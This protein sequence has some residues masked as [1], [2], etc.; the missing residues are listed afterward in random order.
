MTPRWA[1]A[2]PA[3][4]AGREVER[5][6]PPSFSVVIAAYQAEA[7]VGEAIASA[8]AQTAPPLEVVVVDDGSTDGTAGVVAS[9]GDRV[10]FLRRPNGGEGAAKNMGARA[11]RGEF[12]VILD[13]DDTFLPERL[14]ALGTLAAARPDLDVLTTDAWLV[15]DG[16][17]VRRVYDGGHA[18][19][20]VDQR[21]ELMRRNFVFGHAAVRRRRFL[22]V[23][24]FDENLRTTTDWDLWIRLALS[25]SGFGLVA[26]PLATY[27]MRPDSIS[28]DWLTVVAAR[29][30][31]LRKT[32]AAPELSDADRRLVREAAAA[33]ERALRL[34]QARAAMLHAR[35]GARGLAWAVVTDPGQGPRSRLKALLATASPALA[36][37][38][39]V[40]PGAR[41]SA[42]RATRLGDAAVV[43]RREG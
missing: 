37:R 10:R 38:L 16:V 40:R 17:R 15:V 9:F 21:T 14:E 32:G 43:P 34:G 20:V 13:A 27:R 3:P 41:A 42:S 4:A 6:D 36:R 1:L 26:E 23:G 22:A 24:G 7:F 8:L 11:A 35:P 39:L 29:I 5:R 33:Q 25:G 12:V 2:T 31:V 18:F 28:G 19:P 30:E